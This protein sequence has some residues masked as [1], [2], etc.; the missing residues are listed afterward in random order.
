MSYLLIPQKQLQQLSRGLILSLVLHIA[1]VG[2]LL[3]RATTAAQNMFHEQVSPQ[4]SIQLAPAIPIES[5]TPSEPEIVEESQYI[6]PEVISENANV[7]LHSQQAPPKKIS[8][9]KTQKPPTKIAKVIKKPAKAD[10]LPLENSEQVTE[11]SQQGQPGNAQ[12]AS[13]D[14]GPKGDTSEIMAGKNVNGENQIYLAKVRAE[15]ERNKKYPRQA[16]QRRVS[17]RVGVEI[18]IDNQGN[19]IDAQV[20]KSSGNTS[21]DN[22]ALTAARQ[23]R[24]SGPPPKTFAKVIKMQIEFRLMKS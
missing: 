22:S 10:P 8:K 11:Q 9:E 5:A 20:V 4:F 2:F 1:V 14:S 18:I 16:R 7:I 21:L 13:V 24:S 19:I 23:A 17:G 15:I 6:L 3:Y 12:A